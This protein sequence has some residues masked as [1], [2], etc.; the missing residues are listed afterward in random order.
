MSQRETLKAQE[1]HTDTHRKDAG[2]TGTGV[3]WTCG[4]EVW[5]RCRQW[6]M[7]QA[8]PFAGM[9]QSW[10]MTELEDTREPP[11]SVLS[12]DTFNWRRM[13]ARGPR[14]RR[15]RVTCSDN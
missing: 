14:A 3:K 4:Q 6:A 1:R 13:E 9:V 15:V 11:R 2:V 5:E 7:Q 8:A 12:S 10:A